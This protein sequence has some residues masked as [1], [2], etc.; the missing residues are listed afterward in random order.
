MK[1]LRSF[2]GLLNEGRW[3]RESR[4]I[5]K[6]MMRTIR[7]FLSSPS[8]DDFVKFDLTDPVMQVFGDSIVKPFKTALILSRWSGEDAT[9]MDHPLGEFNRE[10]KTLKVAI[11]INTDEGKLA[12]ERKSHDVFEIVRHELEHAVQ[13]GFLMPQPI[14]GVGLNLSGD[15]QMG[16]YRMSPEE[17]EGWVVGLYARAKRERKPF[18]Q[19]LRASLV[20]PDG[21][22]DAK[23]KAAYAASIR[24]ARKRFPNAHGIR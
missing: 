19:L 10:F 24:Y 23:E 6:I 1:Q 20:G 18:E 9:Y 2:I 21:K 17:I 22:M 8:S 4:S 14:G 16:Y 11:S 12:L 7:A 3:E 5:A 13:S 15:D